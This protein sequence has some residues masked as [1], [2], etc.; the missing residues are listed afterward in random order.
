M[1]KLTEGLSSFE[2]DLTFPIPTAPYYLNMFSKYYNVLGY[3][4]VTNA[5]IKVGTNLITP[6]P[7]ARKPS[8]IPIIQ[9]T[10]INGVSFTSD[11][12]KASLQDSIKLYDSF[13]NYIA[14]YN[15][16]FVIGCGGTGG[17]LIRDL[18]RYIST[19]PY[20]DKTLVVLVD[21]DKVE[22]KNLTRQNFIAKDL[23]INKAEVMAKRYSNHYNIQMVSF[24]HHIT[25][26]NITDLMSIKALGDLIDTNFK[27]QAIKTYDTDRSIVNLSII[28]CVD[29]NGT[30]KLLH[31]FLIDS[32]RWSVTEPE[33]YNTNSSSFSMPIMGS[34]SWIDSG[35]E[36]TSGQV[37]A[38][39]DTQF[40]NG[41]FGLLSSLR[42]TQHAGIHF[43]QNTEEAPL[44]LKSLY[45]NSNKFNYT[46][47]INGFRNTKWV[48]DIEAIYDIANFKETDLYPFIQIDSTRKIYSPSDLYEQINITERVRT[49]AQQRAAIL[50]YFMSP[51]SKLGL[52]KNAEYISLPC[53]FANGTIANYQERYKAITAMDHNII[54]SRPKALDD[55]NNL[56]NIMPCLSGITTFPVTAIYPNILKDT[57]ERTN[58]ELS[59]AEHA[60]RDSQTLS[61]NVAAAS[62]ILVYFSQIFAATPAGSF[63]TSYGCSFNRGSSKEFPI[64]F[65]QVEKILK[66][67]E[68]STITVEAKEEIKEIANV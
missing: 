54:P 18:G 4:A 57:D 51:I 38:Y 6:S 42:N 2:K 12:N 47:L 23:N 24:P 64:T 22:L 63:L 53:Y 67:F 31:N 40:A 5:P 33:L 14:T 50:E 27:L 44:V 60:T 65:G 49:V 7:S 11:I 32:S 21:G 25:K 45:F 48:K 9:N 17:Y 28:S 39:Y 43:N 41:I 15:I 1:L 10:L 30:R 61:V 56:L 55:F 58:L 46:R 66:Q 29:N 8:P 20:Q 62:A 35:N 26:D 36:T 37:V 59:C 19:L 16:V 68:P 3:G 52:F 34:I 13:Q